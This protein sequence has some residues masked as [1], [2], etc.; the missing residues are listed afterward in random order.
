MS[1]YNDQKY[2]KE[3]I[4]SI[5]N[6]SFSD[7]EFII[8]DDASSDDTLAEINSYNDNRIK[9]IK[10]KENKGLT[11]NL[12]NALK[13]AKGEY[14][15]RMDGD[16]ISYPERLRKQVEYLDNNREVYLIGTSVQSFGETELF[17]TLPDDS[18]ELRIRMLLRP[19]F[20]HPSF[21]FRRELLEEGF[22]Y[23]EAYRTAQDYDFAARVS[24][25][26]KIGRVK[27]V[28]LKYRIHSKQVSNSLG[29]NQR[30]NADIIRH[31][32][33]SELGVE[34]TAGEEN[35][36]NDWVSERKKD[37]VQEYRAAYSI[38]DKCCNHNRDKNLYD[39][40]KLEV[41][42]KKMLYTWVIRSKNIG[43][44]VQF[45]YICKWNRTNM[46]IFVGEIIRTIHEKIT[47]KRYK[48]RL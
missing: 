12:N 42:L 6:Q 37:T 41:V 48:G 30:N 35:I 31:R 19:V 26:H 34:L 21:M 1:A 14:I 28:L 38:I 22:F 23:D 13:I 44:I 3:A 20:A 29:S 36:Y 24:R 25:E 9:L 47:Y 39:G 11:A 16:D 40:K 10:N 43:F 7:F 45:P 32:L 5:L 27:D 18:E 46:G 2:I 4:D 33:L 8:I 15:A 17:W